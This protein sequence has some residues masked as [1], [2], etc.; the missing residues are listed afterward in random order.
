MAKQGIDY[1]FPAWEAAKGREGEAERMNAASSTPQLAFANPSWAKA[2]GYGFSEAALR[3]EMA[4]RPGPE[5][6]ATIDPKTD[7]VLYG[8]DNP[9]ESESIV[10]PNGHGTLSYGITGCHAESLKRLYGN[11]RQFNQLSEQQAGARQD[12]HSQVVA[13]VS[14][15]ASLTEWR[16]CMSS[17]GWSSFKSQGEAFDKVFKAYV[18]NQSDAHKLE[19]SIAPVDAGCTVSSGYDVAVKAAEKRVAKSASQSM[20]GTIVSFVEL[21]HKALAVATKILST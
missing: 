16:E 4:K 14:V 5:T 7:A 18:S 2:H 8:G 17:H 21:Q 11:L 13:D 20:N 15:S 12:L 9:G 10:L 1:T 19:F 3:A 6:G